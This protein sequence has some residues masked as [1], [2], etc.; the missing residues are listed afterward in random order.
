[1]KQLSINKEKKYIKIVGGQCPVPDIVSIVNEG[2]TLVTLCICF[3]ALKDFT[4][5]T[6]IIFPQ[7]QAQVYLMRKSSEGHYV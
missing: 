2:L 7:H 1:M 5:H 4:Q 6:S 3:R